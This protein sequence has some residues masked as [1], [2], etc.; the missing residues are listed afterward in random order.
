MLILSSIITL[1]V[2]MMVMFVPR[3]LWLFVV[4]MVVT[5]ISCKFDKRA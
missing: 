5:L 3:L 1:A 2:F 4:S